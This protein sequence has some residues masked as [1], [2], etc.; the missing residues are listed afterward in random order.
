VWL[1]CENG[2]ALAWE[3]ARFIWRKITS[4][5][6]PNIST[7]LIKCIAALSFKDNLSKDPER[8]RIL[9]SM[10]IWAIWR[11]RNKIQYSIRT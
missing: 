4:R 7:G 10:R 11:S 5:T 1:E 3:T 2:Q 9:I 8:L 6:W